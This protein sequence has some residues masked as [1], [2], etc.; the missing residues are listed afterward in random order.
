MTPATDPATDPAKD[1]AKDP[2]P[3][4]G[5]LAWW[6]R[7]WVIIAL[8]AA[9]LAVAVL[10]ALPLA[11]GG[12]RPLDPASVAP[13]GARAAAEVLRDQGLEV[14]RIERLDELLAAAGPGTTVVVVDSGV[15]L[16][17]DRLAELAGSRADLV[18]LEPAFPLLDALAP[19]L[20]LAGAAE[21]GGSVEPSCRQPDAE[22]AGGVAAG[23]SR[24]V[25]APD[26]PSD[27]AAVTVCH[28]QGD[29]DAPDAGTY[30]VVRGGDG[31]DVTV[32]GRPEL[33]TNDEL[34]RDGHAALAL[35]TLGRQPVVLWYLPD[36]LDPALAP[37]DDAPG[38]LDLLPSWVAWV[39]AQLLLVGLVAVVWRFRR[40]GRLVPER[41]PA[42]VRSVE[43]AEGRAR[44]YRRS[45]ARDRAAA[46]LRADAAHDLGVR[47]GAPRGAAPGEVAG[48]VSAATGRPPLAVTEALAGPPPRDDAALTRLA[49]DLD[50]LRDAVRDAARTGRTGRAAPSPAAPGPSPA[51]QPSPEEGSHP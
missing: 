50:A 35:R 22:A 51:P 31:A 42:V 28:P 7:N 26:G 16:P 39:A 5:R 13:S 41:L 46:L 25:P 43:T 3:P 29:D 44:L 4:T 34:A 2:D 24:Y 27:P 49:R 37:P 47:L 11:R 1:P 15:P 10:V 32:V 36:P 17:P 40:L 9:A 18:L 8:G 21:P 45:G 23:G 19:E 30:A 12:E 14:R 20:V 6:R 38:P 33:L 48:L